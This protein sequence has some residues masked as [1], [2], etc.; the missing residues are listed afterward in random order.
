MCRSAL[1]DSCESLENRALLAA[2]FPE[3]IDP[4]P[5]VD[6]GFGA[7]IVPL[8]T[9]SRAE[10]T[11]DHVGNG[12]RAEF[13]ADHS[14]ALCYFARRALNFR[15]AMRARTMAISGRHKP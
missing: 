10:L 6:N 12:L 5:S 1:V 9:G 15:D 8:S 11:V 14:L 2:A 3:F 7:E 4:N 13:T